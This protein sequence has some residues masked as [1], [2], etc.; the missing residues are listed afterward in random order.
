M[1]ENFHIHLASNVAPDTFPNNTPSDFKTPLA[2]ELHLHGGV[3]EVAVKDIMY[4]SYVSSTTKADKLHFHKYNY[5]AI[6]SIPFEVQN[7]EY[8]PYSEKLTVLDQKTVEEQAKHICSVIQSTLLGK[9]NILKLE[10]IPSTKKF[11]LHVFEYVLIELSDELRNY[12]GFTVN[13]FFKGTHETWA[14]SFDKK[15]KETKGLE[16]K[17]Y[18]VQGLESETHDLHQ[19]FVYDN[20]PVRIASVSSAACQRLCVSVQILNGK[21]IINVHRKEGNYFL[22]QFDEATAK[23]FHMCPFYFVNTVGTKT[24]TLHIGIPQ[25]NQSREGKT[26]PSIT[27]YRLTPKEMSSKNVSTAANDFI[28]LSQNTN[29]TSPRQFL[30]QL[31]SKAKTFNYKFSFSPT[32][33]R[34]HLENNGK[35]CLKMSESLATILGFEFDGKQEYLF[36][37]K[38]YRATYP[39]LLHRGINHLFVYS[40]IVDSVLVG[41]T[42]A[43]LMLVC[44]FKKSDQSMMIHQEFLNPTFVPISRTSIHQIDILIRDDAGEPIPFLYGKTVLTLQVRKRQN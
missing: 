5:S 8:V 16:I 33:A 38:S 9:E 43:P 27:L 40:N 14:S 29:F 18:D 22:L 36:S 31:N 32:T 21:L 24:F 41:N 26:Y 4:P 28:E 12:L 10:Y 19:H 44:A 37:K 39:P 25:S 15:P 42:K 3:W 1:E 17:A 35:Y 30:K 2:E 20:K 6:K 23:A 34:F 7:G 13:L 11:M